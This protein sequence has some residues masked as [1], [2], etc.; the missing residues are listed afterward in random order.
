MQSQVSSL[1]DQRQLK[2]DTQI[3][4]RHHYT[5]AIV[6]DIQVTYVSGESHMSH[7]SI[8]HHICLP[9]ITYVS[10][11]NYILKIVTRIGI[12]LY[13]SSYLK[14]PAQD[15]THIR[16]TITQLSNTWPRHQKQYKIQEKQEKNIH[17]KSNI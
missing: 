8:T 7:T 1:R 15:C 3:V 12:F 2:S 6:T 16:W 17:N 4:F 10:H 13:D 5:L 14:D 9:P 11:I